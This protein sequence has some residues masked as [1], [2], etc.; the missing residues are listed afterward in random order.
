[1]NIAYVIN[2]R[3][4]NTLVFISSNQIT[5]PGSNTRSSPGTRFK[6]PL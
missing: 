6:E 3:S 4:L 2:S 1:M 5:I